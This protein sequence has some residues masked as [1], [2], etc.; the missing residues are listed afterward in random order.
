MCRRMRRTM[1]PSSLSL[2]LQHHGRC[3]F[4]PPRPKHRPRTMTRRMHPPAYPPPLSPPLQGVRTIGWRMHTFIFL[5]LFF[6]VFSSNIYHQFFYFISH[7]SLHSLSHLNFSLNS[8]M[9]SDNFSFLQ[10]QKI[11]NKK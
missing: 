10:A 8:I 4:Y 9:N 6:F 2:P 5:F 7:L 3:T 11:K 1:H